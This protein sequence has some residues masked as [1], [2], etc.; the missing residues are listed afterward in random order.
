[1]WLECIGVVIL[2]GIVERRY[3]DILII[4]ITFPYI[5]SF[6]EDI[7]ILIKS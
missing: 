3:I 5:S 1:M 4:S 7:Y 2:V 6:Y